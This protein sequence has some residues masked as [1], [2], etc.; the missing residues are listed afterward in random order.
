MSVRLE[1]IID[2]IKLGTALVRLAAL[3]FQAGD[4]N[5]GIETRTDAEEC[6]TSAEC[7]SARLNGEDLEI[8][9]KSIKTLR[10]AIDQ[11]STS[12]YCKQSNLTAKD[13]E[14]TA[15]RNWSLGKQLLRI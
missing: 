2:D 11:L 15:F 14:A 3:Y 5:Q 12:K 8:A 7:S 10:S 6:H 9:A 13:L 1:L 4:T